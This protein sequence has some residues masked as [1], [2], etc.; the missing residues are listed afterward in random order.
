MHPWVA[1]AFIRR[2]LSDE[3]V[4]KVRD[5]ELRETSS[6]RLLTGFEVIQMC[7]LKTKPVPDYEMVAM[8]NLHKT[9]EQKILWKQHQIEDKKHDTICVETPIGKWCKCA[10][11]ASEM[12]QWENYANNNYVKPKPPKSDGDAGDDLIKPKAESAPAQ[13]AFTY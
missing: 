8:T 1:R 9:W 11:P 6:G 12:H 4:N 3:Q 13:D 7:G 10:T 2:M 5:F